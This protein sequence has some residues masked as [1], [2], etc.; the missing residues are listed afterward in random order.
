MTVDELT[1]VVPELVTTISPV[2]TVYGAC[3]CPSPISYAVGS[4]SRLVEGGDGCS[5][6]YPTLSVLVTSGGGI[7]SSGGQSGSGIWSVFSYI[8]P[9][10]NANDDGT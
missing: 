3:T 8:A 2:M 1:T 6:E 4:Q 7:V 10:G 9:K 5:I